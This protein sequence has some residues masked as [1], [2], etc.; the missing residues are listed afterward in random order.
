MAI[1][2]SYK[3]KETFEYIFEQVE[4]CI[5]IIEPFFKILTVD[6][7]YTPDYLIKSE[8]IVEQ[9]QSVNL[10]KL[11]ICDIAYAIVFYGASYKDR[12]PI[13]RLYKDDYN[14]ILMRYI[15]YLVSKKPHTL[16]DSFSIW[17]K[18][19]AIN[20]KELVAS[21]VHDIRHKIDRLNSFRVIGYVKDSLGFYESIADTRYFDGHHYQLGHYFRHLFQTV[22]YI[23]ERK[24]L[25]YR[26]KYEYAKTL[27]AQLS[28]AE[29]YVFFFNSVSKAGRDWELNNLLGHKSLILSCNRQLVTKY[30]LIKNIPDLHCEGGINI[31]DF[32]PF[33]DY[34]FLPVQH[35]RKNIISYFR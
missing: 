31:R 21:C 7:I 27:R 23:D 5:S 32:Y 2:G 22:K 6:E 8:R 35:D 20:K 24:I 3:G 9:R 28:T 18:F 16:D 11:A 15:I 10:K 26:E 4:N 12:S 17:E 25:S 30:N 33:V 13:L 19:Y 29:Q 14:Q 34:E 1:R